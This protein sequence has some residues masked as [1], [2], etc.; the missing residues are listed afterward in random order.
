MKGV[1]GAIRN[2]TERKEAEEAL[3]KA[4]EDAEAANVAKSEF[5]ANMSHEIRTPMNV[6]IGMVD[7]ALE[8]D[9]TTEQREYLQ[10]VKAS[11]DSL[12]TLIN[13]ILDLSKIESRK[14]E[15]DLVE[16]NLSDNLAD[17]LKTLALRADEKGLEL[18]CRIPPDIPEI[19]VGD[20]GRLR[21]ILVNLVGNAIKFTERGEVVVH[22]ERGGAK[23][24][25][26][27]TA[28]HCIRHRYRYSA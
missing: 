21:Q 2:V 1:V 19:L 11:S 7:L 9:L 20:P 28:F 16:F 18:A 14:L 22:V 13:D 24:G 23:R 3:R 8:T 15:L 27:L 17:T 26:D 25:Q 6:I 10:T 4:K 5:L 12:L